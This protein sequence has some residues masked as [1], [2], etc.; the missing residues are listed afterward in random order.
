MNLRTLS[1][2]LSILLS[3]SIGACGGSTPASS[4]TASDALQRGGEPVTLKFGWTPATRMSVVEKVL[5]EG[6]SSES[7][8]DMAVETDPRG[9]R[10]RYSNVR[11]SPAG[12]AG[13]SPDAIMAAIM[14]AVRSDII[15]STSGALSSVEFDAEQLT[16]A[17]EKALPA[18]ATQEQKGL[19]MGMVGGLARGAAEGQAREDWGD[20]V[21]TWSGKT[22]TPGAEVKLD[23]TH[24]MAMLGDVS[25]D[26]SARLEGTMGCPDGQGTCAKLVFD[27]VTR[28]S[29]T[30]QEITVKMRRHF[31]LIADVATL[32]PQSSVLEVEGSIETTPGEPGEPIPPTRVERT[33]K[34]L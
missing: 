10:V 9:L 27:S 4:T 26:V 8:F 13:Q 17:L 24:Q 34:R 3:L 14:S 22:L 6:Q 18:D 21:E 23:R 25:F 2:S 11:S 15:V 33:Y 5:S 19:M 20:L 29:Q 28:P 1:C 12:G 7:T 16:Q 32:L 31:E 30:P